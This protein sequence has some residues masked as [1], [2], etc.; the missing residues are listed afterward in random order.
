MQRIF[1]VLAVTATCSLAVVP[2]AP[3]GQAQARDVHRAMAADTG[4]GAIEAGAG[5]ITVGQQSSCDFSELQSALD[6]AAGEYPDT[7]RIRVNRNVEIADPPLVVRGAN[8]DLEGGYSDCE[9][10]TRIGTTNLSARG[11]TRVFVVAEA[12]TDPSRRS[13]L[14]LRHIQVL[15]GR[16]FNGAGI[17]VSGDSEVYLQDSNVIGNSATLRGGGIEVLEG[18]ALEISGPSMISGNDAGRLDRSGQGGGVYCSGGGSRVVVGAG[19]EIGSNQAVGDGADPARGGGVFVADACSFTMIG[20]AAVNLNRADEGGGGYL[21]GATGALLMGSDATGSLAVP[22]FENNRVAGS[23]G[24][25]SLLNGTLMSAQRAGFVGNGFLLDAEP[26]GGG[27]LHLESGSR[28]TTSVIEG[29]PSDCPQGPACSRFTG[30]RADG[31]PMIMVDDD[32]TLRL[33]GM[34]IAENGG[35]GASLVTVGGSRVTVALQNNF[36][37]RNPVG[38]VLDGIADGANISL[39]HN[40]IADTPGLQAVMFIEDDLEGFSLAFSKNLVMEEGVPVFAGSGQFFNE[41]WECHVGPTFQTPPFD[42]QT[43][44]GDADFADPVN[45]DY[46]LAPKS[47]AIDRC[48]GSLFE[49]SSDIDGEFRPVDHV[50]IAGDLYTDA[51]ADEVQGPV[52]QR[53]LIVNVDGPGTVLGSINVRAGLECRETCEVGFDSLSLVDLEAVPDPGFGVV[54]EDCPFP[55]DEV[56]C[57]VFMD[58]DQSATVR[59]PPLHD[60]SV[61]VVG[62]GQV[63]GG[64]G[65]V[66]IECPGDNCKDQ[67]VGGETAL[68][69]AIPDKESVFTGWQGDC[70]FAGNDPVCELTVNQPVE[71]EA[72]FFS[73]V[74]FRDD[75]ETP[76]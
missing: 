24:A 6:E 75:F 64:E 19:V 39:V 52:A 40:T 69:V 57:H 53:R 28:F 22:H 37:V 29:V 25:L 9:S 12:L 18:S 13:R 49:Q 32:S 50:A 48:D 67:V 7:V 56:F 16:A 71:I 41:T 33:R 26:T 38:H 1:G 3:A 44:I 11:E 45:L 2:A 63:F 54:W 4:S 59:F 61:R 8:V 51:G 46:H 30:N 35:P 5:A 76:R 62:P 43:L 36:V 27:T 58:G 70:A 20:D 73:P 31:V 60:L 66:P 14:T 15:D 34:L 65:S 74:I 68:L 23:G 10:D 55:D 42:S 21:D 47:E 17:Q 72:H